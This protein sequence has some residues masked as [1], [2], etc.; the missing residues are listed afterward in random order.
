MRKDPARND[1][2]EA[3]KLRLRWIS[4]AIGQNE[5][6]PQKGSCGRGIR[7]QRGSRGQIPGQT[8][9]GKKGEKCSS[10]WSYL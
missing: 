6:F 3:E 9:G 4:C 5:S 2:K 10:N 1:R 8:L 7:L